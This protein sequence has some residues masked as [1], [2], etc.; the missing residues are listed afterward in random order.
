MY[1]YLIEYVYPYA[2]DEILACDIYAVSVDEALKWFYHCV[3][4]DSIVVK[5]VLFLFCV[6][7]K[8]VL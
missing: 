2:Q 4:D 3:D 7:D 6:D 1:C 5:S 8:E